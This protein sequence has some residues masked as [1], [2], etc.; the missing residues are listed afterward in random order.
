MGF[1]KK[2]DFF[3]LVL[4]SGA[5]ITLL[6]LSVRLVSSDQAASAAA[7]AEVA[8]LAEVAL[9][10]TSAANNAALFLTVAQLDGASSP[11]IDQLTAHALDAVRELRARVERLT[12]QASSRE[13]QQ[14]SSAHGDFERGLVALTSQPDQASGSEQ[15][16]AEAVSDAYQELSGVLATIRDARSGDV[17]IAARDVGRVA[18]AARFLAVVVVPLLVLLGVI[19][20]IRQSSSRRV[21]EAQL[22]K[23]R[24][25][26]ASKD[27]FIANISHELRTPLTGIYGFALAINESEDGLTNHGQ[28]MMELIVSEA[29][30]LS[31]MVDDL[32]TAGRID[33]NALTFQIER[34]DLDRALSEVMNPFTMIGIDVRYQPIREY[35]MA[36]ALRLRQI[37]R[38]LLSNA[39]K[40][41]E[42]EVSVSGG[43]RGDKV[44]V[45][46]M[47]NGP[48]VDS[49][50]EGRLFER[51]VHDGASA[52]LEGSVGLGLAIARTLAH[53]M[54]GEIGYSRE[55]GVTVFSLELTAS[56]EEHGSTVATDQH[57]Q[58]ALA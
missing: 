11:V 7:D 34:V 10:A 29:A 14:I 54:S 52:L 42:G 6:A 30:E 46:V 13:A 38:N 18:D 21:L 37:V 12:A 33:A 26:S 45:E 39:V 36:D 20:R 24:A 47:D 3:Q 1:L 57:E 40:Y 17:F 22:Q 35:V 2:F 8:I 28:E 48:G 56:V 4:L 53:G 27:E 19:R 55:G 58:P 25:I 16:G 43:R 51:Y 9:S 49:S 50:V 44:V 23:E 15:K 41:G 32:V 31:R 5:I